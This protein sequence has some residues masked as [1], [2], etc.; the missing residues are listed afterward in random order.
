MHCGRRATSKGHKSAEELWWN[1]STK[2]N[3]VDG[4]RWSSNVFARPLWFGEINIFY[5]ASR[6]LLFDE[7]A[8][9][10][11]PEFVGDVLDLMRTLAA[12]GLTMIVVTHEIGC[13]RG[14]ADSVVF[15]DQGVVV[16][17]AP[18]KHPEQPPEPAN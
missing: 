10:V 18:R 9:A 16:E 4:E 1:R 11:D 6:L 13:E 2:R 14:A 3:F 15:R 12:D 5:G 7:P 8:S 17:S